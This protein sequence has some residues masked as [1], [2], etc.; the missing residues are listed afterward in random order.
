MAETINRASKIALDATETW[1]SWVHSFAG[2]QEVAYFASTMQHGLEVLYLVDQCAGRCKGCGR[3]GVKAKDLG[4]TDD[5]WKLLNGKW[6][7]DEREGDVIQGVSKRYVEVFDL[8]GLGWTAAHPSFLFAQKMDRA[9]RNQQQGEDKG[10]FQGIRI[11]VIE[12]EEIDGVDTKIR[13]DCHMQGV[14]DGPMGLLNQENLDAFS[15]YIDAD[16]VGANAAEGRIFRMA[17]GWDRG[18]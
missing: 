5:V 14:V 9:I 3:E 16:T 8:G 12:D 18:L 6:S 10:K 2:L 7:G 15:S 13:V 17:L 1:V 4:K 11:L